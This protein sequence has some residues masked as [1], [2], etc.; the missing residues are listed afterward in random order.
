MMRYSG[1]NNAR[2]VVLEGGVDKS[3]DGQGCAIL[4]LELVPKSLIFAW[5]SC[6]K[7]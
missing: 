5:K 4:A 6:P 7:I 3:M 1:N 2:M